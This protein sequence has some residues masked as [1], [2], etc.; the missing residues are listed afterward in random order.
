MRGVFVFC[1]PVALAELPQLVFDDA[2]GMVF[3]E[4]VEEMVD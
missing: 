2:R 3:I 4:M 1:A